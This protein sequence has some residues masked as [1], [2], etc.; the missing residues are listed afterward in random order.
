MLFTVIISVGVL[1]IFAS[2]QHEIGNLVY[3]FNIAFGSN[4]VQ[5]PLMFTQATPE[6]LL[7][8]CE[9]LTMKMISLKS[10]LI[11]NINLILVFGIGFFASVV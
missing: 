5:N 3:D 8:N 7:A 1:L 6:Q 9:L 11:L 4:F 10:T 2:T